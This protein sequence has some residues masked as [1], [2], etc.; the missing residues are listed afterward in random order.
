MG[1]AACGGN[2]PL[3]SVVVPV[4]NV[5]PYLRKCVDSILGQT[6]RNLE[7]ILVDDGSPDGCPAI[8]DEYAEKDRR[9]KVI[10]KLNGGL[11][12]ARNV[13]MES[14]I[15]KYLMF[16]D[17]DDWLE[18]NSV[19]IL[20]KA[21]LKYNAQLVIGGTRRVE[22]VTLRT[23]KA[24]NDGTLQV[25]SNTQAMSNFFQ[26]GCA[27]WGRLYLR[28][29]HDDIQFPTGEINEDEAIV[30]LL[31]ERCKTVVIVGEVVYNYRYRPESITTSAF[32][33][34][35]LAWYRHCA[36]NLAWIKSHH[37]EFELLAAKRLCDSVLWSL[38]EIALSDHEFTSQRIELLDDVKKHYTYYRSLTLNKAERMRLFAIHHFPFG[39][40]RIIEQA[41]RKKHF[42]SNMK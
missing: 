2:E 13:G 5:E 34:K 21:S 36:D 17:S 26:N 18:V 4:Y 3:I 8:C 6:Y 41:R 14:A 10:H 28:E 1:D 32:F 11:S 27:A 7:I 12:D 38:R 30:L 29:I 9:V 39:V 25:L 40:Y 23:M 19:K 35:K 24:E 20:L 22:D 37:P 42:R 33:G 31:L 15:G 16:V